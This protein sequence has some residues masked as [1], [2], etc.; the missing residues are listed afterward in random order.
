LSEHK[1]P[2]V[3]VSSSTTRDEF[4]GIDSDDPG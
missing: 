1:F 3:H 2:G 4:P